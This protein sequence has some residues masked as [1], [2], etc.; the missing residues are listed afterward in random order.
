MT[1]KFMQKWDINAKF[2]KSKK[3]EEL[4]FMPSNKADS[5]VENFSQI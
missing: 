5:I 3:Y 2:K 1:A 4:A